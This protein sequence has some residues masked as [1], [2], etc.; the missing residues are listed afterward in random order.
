MKDMKDTKSKRE[1]IK[2]VI[3]V[4]EIETANSIFTLPTSI[5]DDPATEPALG[6]ENKEWEDDEWME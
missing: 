1:Y 5:S 3:T 2:P 4:T 6:R